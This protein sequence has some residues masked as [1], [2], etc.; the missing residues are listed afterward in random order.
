MP[1]P[2]STL[3]DELASRFRGL[4]GTRRRV[5]GL[6]LSGGVSR[7]DVERV[8]EALFLSYFSLF[9]V[10]IEDLF[11]GLLVEGRGLIATRPGV[12]PRARISSH[13][14]A[15]DLVSNNRGYVEWLPYNRTEER[16]EVYFTGG[17]PF[18]ALAAG[19]KS[20]IQTCG[21]IRNAIAHRSRYAKQVFET[22]VLVG[23]IL[24]PRERTPAGFLRSSLTG[25]PPQTRHE[26]YVTKL[27]GIAR[28]LAV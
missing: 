3:A 12:R 20:D 23:L 24:H 18:S 7:Y 16:A 25:F 27:L 4:E 17:R 8:Y 28:D 5:E 21:R 14:V 15:R 9:E 11:I 2:S 1:R 6:A 10:F 19:Q 26:Y 22:K 13:R